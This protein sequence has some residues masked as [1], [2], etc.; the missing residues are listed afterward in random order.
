VAAIRKLE[1]VL[2]DIARTEHRHHMSVM[3]GRLVAPMREALASF[4]GFD[5]ALPQFD[6]NAQGKVLADGS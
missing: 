3:P 1:E 4:I 2:Y 5:V 6:R